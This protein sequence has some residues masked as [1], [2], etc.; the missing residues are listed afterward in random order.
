MIPREC[1]IN[2]MADLIG[3]DETYSGDR[4]NDPMVWDR[5]L[6]HLYKHM[7]EIAD[8]PIR[9]ALNSIGTEEF[10]CW[11]D[12]PGFWSAIQEEIVRRLNLVKTLLPSKN[13][14][15]C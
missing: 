4:L 14:G 13:Q 9:D 5:F 11:I 12:D 7:D 2:T 8:E 15:H 10:Q 6:D 3:L 1:M